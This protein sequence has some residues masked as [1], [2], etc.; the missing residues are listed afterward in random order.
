MPFLTGVKTFIEPCAGDGRLVRHLEINGL[1][2]ISAF[3]TEPDS[4][5]IRYGDALTEPLCGTIITNPPWYRPVLHA[6]INR[7][8]CDA[9]QAWLLFDADWIHTVQ[10]RPYKPY[11]S[12][13][14]P[15]GR[16]RW[17]EGS[18]MSGKDNVA[19]YRFSRDAERTI[20][21]AR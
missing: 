12:D 3:D 13:V 6:M 16:V 17:I 10:S 1:Q 11:C 4:L 18:T 5:F 21:H 14:V 7:F 9:D 2:C 15:I 8:V 20:I 19:W